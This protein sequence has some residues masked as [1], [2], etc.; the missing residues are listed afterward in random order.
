[1]K[2]IVPLCIALVFSGTT[3]MQG[4]SQTSES[5]SVAAAAA[6]APPA[7]GFP[8]SGPVTSS[9]IGNGIWWRPTFDEAVIEKVMTDAE[10]WGYRNVLVESFWNGET[11]FPSRT[12]PSKDGSDKDW[13]TTMCAVARRHN[14]RVHAWIHTLYWRADRSTVQSHPLLS[15][16]PDWV[17]LPREDTPT[18]AGESRT[19]FVSPAIPGVRRALGSLID[20][21]C[22]RDIA[23]VNLDYIRYPSGGEDYG[24]N[25]ASIE[26]FKAATGLSP[27][28][29]KPDP[30]PGSDWMKWVHFRENQVTELV[31][32]LC[33]RIRTRSQVRKTR[34]LVSAAFFPGYAKERGKNPKFQD[35][36]TWVKRGYLDFSTPMCYSPQL[37]GLEGELKEIRAAHAG[38]SVACLPGIAVGKFYSPHPSLAEQ[39]ELL[40]K[41]GYSN[42]MVFKYE[43]VKAELDQ[44]QPK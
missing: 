26:K 42:W 18:S 9:E 44:K 1:V 43:T 24:Y 13:L 36:T 25:P 7:A 12:F 23:G 40:K 28:D 21:L 6:L 4:V 20:E 27:R 41:T 39:G 11:I 34:I 29:L 10:S 37:P 19:A 22:E 15:K 35:W 5:A 16:H 8:L 33:E 38:T 3:A 31:S 14:L 32:E 17:E 2:A 30:T